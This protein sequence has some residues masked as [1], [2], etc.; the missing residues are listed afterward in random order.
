MLQHTLVLCARLSARRVGG[1]VPSRTHKDH[2]DVTPIPQPSCCST[3]LSCLVDFSSQSGHPFTCGTADE[4]SPTVSG[5]S[6]THTPSAH[7][8]NDLLATSSPLYELLRCFADRRLRLRQRQRLAE[9]VLRSATASTR[10]RDDMNRSKQHPHRRAACVQS[11]SQSEQSQHPLRP[12]GEA[13]VARRWWQSASQRTSRPRCVVPRERGWVVH[14]CAHLRHGCI[15]VSHPRF[16]DERGGR[17]RRPHPNAPH[18][19]SYRPL[20]GAGLRRCGELQ[21]PRRH[22][23]TP[24]DT[25]HARRGRILVWVCVFAAWW[26]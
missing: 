8:V 13:T 6:T 10:R 2:N 20:G 1:D 17:H 25:A 19:Q 23:S 7:G 9:A 14:S 12:R 21:Q 3:E 11:K 22:E 18:R 26:E 16:D 24:D 4:S 15:H 5:S